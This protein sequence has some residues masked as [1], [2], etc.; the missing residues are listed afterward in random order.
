MNKMSLSSRIIIAVASLS[1]IAT[2]FLP[3]WFIFLIAPQY[4][5]GLTMH[6]WLNQLTGQIEIINGLNHYIGMKHIKAEMFPEFSYLAYIIGFFILY[7]LFVAITGKRKLLLSYLGLVILGGAAAM[8]DFYQ[9]GYDYGHN[10]DPKAAI[11][12]PGLSYQP[13][14]FGHKILLNFDAYSYPD[15]GGWIV[16]GAGSLVLL[17][18]AYEWYKNRKRKAILAPL[19][20]AAPVAALFVFFLSSCT[21]KPEAFS[22]GKDVC[23]DCKM[24]IMDAK[25]GGEIL[26]QKGRVYKFDDTHCLAYFIKSGNIK[27]EDIAQIVFADYQNPNTFLNAK[28]ALFVV[29]KELKSPMNGNAAAFKTKDIAGQKATET[30][31]SIKSWDE[32]F[33]SL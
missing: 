14:L 30:N 10:L 31:G 16:I 2:F 6:I 20:A 1:L 21:A 3:V 19:K 17:V 9:W 24:T 29:S 26:T 33:Q 25:Y 12:I 4:P 13:P 11:Q 18:W 8:V 7:G 28:E 32:L 15:I 5:E 22:L 27:K 23:D